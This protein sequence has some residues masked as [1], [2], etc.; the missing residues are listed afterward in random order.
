[1]NVLTDAT[2]FC[3]SEIDHKLILAS[4]IYKLTVEVKN[5]WVRKVDQLLLK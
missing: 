1:M 4:S 5:L 2:V 3:A